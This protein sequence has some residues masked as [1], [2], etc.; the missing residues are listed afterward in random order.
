MQ[1]YNEVNNT[2]DN[3]IQN[4]IRVWISTKLRNDRH[5]KHRRK[6]KNPRSD[7]NSFSDDS[8]ERLISKSNDAPNQKN[9]LERLAL[10]L[11]RLMYRGCD[12]EVDSRKCYTRDE[13]AAEFELNREEMNLVFTN[14]LSVEIDGKRNNL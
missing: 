11:E 13:V 1:T 3:N 14:D 5:N 12:S 4:N 6:S 7:E 8:Q 9:K 10:L 2:G